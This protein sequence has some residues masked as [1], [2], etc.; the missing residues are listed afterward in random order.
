MQVKNGH[1]LFSSTAFAFDFSASILHSALSGG[2]ISQHCAIAPSRFDRSFPAIL[3]FEKFEI[4]AVFQHFSNLDLTKNLSPNR[5][6]ELRSAA[7]T[8]SEREGASFLHNCNNIRHY[9]K[10]LFIDITFA[11]AALLF[12]IQ[13]Q[14]QPF[15]R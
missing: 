2:Y 3:R 13:P 5:I 4:H 14:L 7:I 6:A 10:L 8:P 1:L 15:S 12:L 11:V 9:Q